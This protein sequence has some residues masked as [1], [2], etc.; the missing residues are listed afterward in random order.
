MTQNISCLESELDVVRGHNFEL[1]DKIKEADQIESD[2]DQLIE[3][4]ESFC[5]LEKILKDIER[6]AP[7]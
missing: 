4:F 7:S 5:Y 3:R 6:L 1:Q 2:Y